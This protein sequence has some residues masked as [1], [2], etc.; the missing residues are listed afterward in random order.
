MKLQDDLLNNLE[1]TNSRDFWKQIGKI[2]IS[3]ERQN[4]IP[5]EILEENGDI[6]ADK[7]GVLDRRESDYRTLFDENMQQSAYDDRHLKNVKHA[8]IIGVS[9]DDNQR[10][11]ISCLNAHIS[12]KEIEEA[13]KRLNLGKLLALTISLRKC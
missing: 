12:R 9:V 5:F 6:I 1:K 3:K 10:P 7:K 4:T 13:V 2:G 11:D 8:N